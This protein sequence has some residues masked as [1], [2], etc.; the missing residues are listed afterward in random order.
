MKVALAQINTAVGDLGGNETAI[1]AAYQRGVQAGTE[2][3]V[4]PELAVCGY[5][6]RDLLHKGTFIEENGVT[7]ERLARATGRAGLLLGYV[8]RNERRPG[9]EATN[10]AALLQ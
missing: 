7:I 6:P 2:L 1:L 9:R 5:P 4:C 3:V 10:P 8:G